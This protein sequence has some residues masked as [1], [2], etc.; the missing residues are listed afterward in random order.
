MKFEDPQSVSCPACGCLSE[1]AVDELFARRAKCP[2][3]GRV[4]AETSER[5]HRASDEWTDFVIAI[6][7]SLEVERQNNL[8]H[9]EAAFGTVHCLQDL[10]IATEPLLIDV[11][12][13]DHRGAAV[14]AVR[15]AFSAVFPQV[16]CPA[17]SDR[18]AHALRPHL[19][20]IFRR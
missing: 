4:L 13:P 12:E 10:I 7:L 20:K 16:D 15:N 9:D 17:P 11:P 19:H 1:Q 3:W 8:R 5:M 18:L 6:R 14:E 2:A